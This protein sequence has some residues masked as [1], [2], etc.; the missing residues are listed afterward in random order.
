MFEIV[1]NRI[2][3]S[4]FVNEDH[5]KF[6]I[7]YIINNPDKPEFSGKFKISKFKNDFYIEVLDN[8][9]VFLG[10]LKIF[11]IK[12]RPSNIII[13]GTCETKE[14]N[15]EIINEN[16]KIEVDDTDQ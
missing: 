5:L 4:A 6:N 16:L 15:D 13:D 3:A 11:N 1:K 12:N 14:V 8:D 10:Y 7:S 2:S 9:D